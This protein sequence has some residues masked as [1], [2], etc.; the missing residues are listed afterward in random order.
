MVRDGLYRSVAISGIAFAILFVLTSAV[1]LK[2]FFWDTYNVSKSL[3]DFDSHR[4][5]L[6]TGMWLRAILLFPAI[7]IAVG[8]YQFTEITN[9]YAAHVSALLML[10]Y[11]LLSTVSGWTGVVIGVP[12]EEYVPGAVNAH[13]LEV[14]ADSLFWTQDNLITMSNIA[15]AASVA[16]SSLVAMRREDLPHW[17][18]TAGMLTLPFVLIGATSFYFQVGILFH[19][20]LEAPVYLAGSV[21]AGLALLVWIV[22]LVGSCM[23]RCGV[24]KSSEPPRSGL[25]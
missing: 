12:A 14:L 15:L 19:R 17:A 3:Q 7:F 16:I 21:G 22:G 11:G 13:A 9:R 4:Y 20:N 8:L 23:R 1:Q 5:V 2:P 24:K 6:M 25:L 18:A 10:A